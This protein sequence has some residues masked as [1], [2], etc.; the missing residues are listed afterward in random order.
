M[1]N[2]Q[3]M[4]LMTSIEMLILNNIIFHIM[5]HIRMT[6]N[7]S[8]LY[9]MNIKTVIHSPYDLITDFVVDTKD[10]LNEHFHEITVRED[11]ANQ[12][13]FI[14]DLNFKKVFLY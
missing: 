13:N 11:P 6:L 4:I 9:Q 1:R 3:R 8:T 2:S 7:K 14:A 10:N 5:K 12:I